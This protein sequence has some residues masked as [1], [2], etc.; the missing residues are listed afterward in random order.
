MNEFEKFS[1]NEK[2]IPLYGNANERKKLIQSIDPDKKIS[3]ITSYDSLR[4]DIENYKDIHFDL[5][6]LDEAQFIK[7]TQAKKTQSVK[8]L[9]AEHRLV[10]TG[11]PIENSVLDLWSIYD[12]LMPVSFLLFMK[13]QNM[14]HNNHL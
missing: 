6:I 8:T 11:T 14:L 10:L 7:N 4:N 3:Y 2:I 1:E 13:S 9:N 12:F 5:V